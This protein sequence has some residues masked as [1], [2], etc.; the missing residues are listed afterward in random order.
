MDFPYDVA[1]ILWHVGTP[2]GGVDDRGPTLAMLQE[3]SF[4]GPSGGILSEVITA[5][6]K[7]S[8]R[9]QGLPSPITIGG[10]M[11]QDQRIYILAEGT[12]ALGFLKV[13]RKR[14]FVVPPVKEA[15]K[16]QRSR[17]TVSVQEAL[18]ELTP[19]C[20]LDFY[21]QE[22]CQR[23]G[24]GKRLFD[25]MLR[26]EGVRPSQM[27]YDRPSPKFLGFLGKH[28]SLRRFVPQNNNF[29]VFDDYFSEMSSEKADAADCDGRRLRAGDSRLMGAA[30]SMGAYASTGANHDH[31]HGTSGRGHYVAGP[32]A[33]TLAMGVT[34]QVLQ[35][36]STMGVG[37]MLVGA[38]AVAAAPVR[39]D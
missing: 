24:L 11:P 32:A 12:Q 25:A 1:E 15:H 22:G 3:G 33:S 28:F 38:A 18:V 27:A 23:S 30:H 34:K 20:A 37:W 2:L 8:A 35:T 19:L 7:A 9:A 13:G 31:H 10:Q 21:V 39:M 36:S 4:R 6:G 17:S 26:R 29:V 16:V 14:L 5:M